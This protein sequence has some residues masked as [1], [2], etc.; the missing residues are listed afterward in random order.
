[1]NIKFLKLAGV[2]V[3]IA[4]TCMVG[5]ANP[6]NGSIAFSG[7]PVFNS[8]PI[9]GATAFTALNNVYVNPGQQTG[10]YSSIPNF[11]TTTF[12]PFTF[13]PPAGS[14]VPLWVVTVGVITYSFE[15]T[16]MISS[17]DSVLNIWNIG[18]SGIASITGYDN[19]VGTWN[20]AAGN[21]GGSF[22]FGSATTV[23]DGGMTVMLLG[24]ALSGLAL[25]RR[26][27]AA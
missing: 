1:M 13:S 16:S 12:T 2:V 18:G 14:V 26:K 3:A 6:I 21:Q 9:S 8:T 22:F 10:D 11:S 23:P 15:A 7:N 24:T 5:Q 17:F 25:L 20:L 27:L 4:G 19:T